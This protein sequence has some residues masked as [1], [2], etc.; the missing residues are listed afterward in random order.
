MRSV[1]A[2]KDKLDKL[3]EECTQDGDLLP[4]VHDETAWRTQMCEEVR[5]QHIGNRGHRRGRER[6]N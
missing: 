2:C 5:G 6:R 1:R 3:R 4:R